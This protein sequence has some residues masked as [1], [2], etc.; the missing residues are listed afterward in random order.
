MRISPANTP[1]NPTPE[2]MSEEI[3]YYIINAGGGKHTRSGSVWSTGSLES[4][5]AKLWNLRRTGGGGPYHIVTSEGLSLDDGGLTLREANP[6]KQDS[7]PYNI[8]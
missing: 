8:D 7:D 4:A 6:T 2:T 3:Q 5:K 1:A